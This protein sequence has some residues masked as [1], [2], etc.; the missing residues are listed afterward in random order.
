MFWCS[1][2][3]SLR[4]PASSVSHLLTPCRHIHL[5]VTQKSKMCIPVTVHAYC[6]FEGCA[7]GPQSRRT[8]VQ[9]AGLAHENLSQKSWFRNAHFIW[10]PCSAYEIQY[11]VAS[12]E[13]NFTPSRKAT[14][15]DRQNH[16]RWIATCNYSCVFEFDCGIHGKGST[17]GLTGPKSSLVDT[18]KLL[19]IWATLQYDKEQRLRSGSDG[20]YAL[21]PWRPFVTSQAFVA[22][23][24]LQLMLDALGLQRDPLMQSQKLII[25]APPSTTYTLDLNLQIAPRAQRLQ[26]SSDGKGRTTAA[27]PH[28]GR[29]IL[30]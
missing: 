16:G 27:Q 24:W 30:K 25:K 22:L 28:E 1:R 4:D 26:G 2:S 7:R 29:P 3:S 23:N 17:R 9:A 12:N 19:P 21:D 6:R 11:S 10:L 13:M 15:Q 5:S 14:G 8:I 20:Q 18:T